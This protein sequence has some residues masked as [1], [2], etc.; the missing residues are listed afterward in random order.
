LNV[1]I[2]NRAAGFGDNAP[3]TDGVRDVWVRGSSFLYI[4]NAYV[5]IFMS[6]NFSSLLPVD[7]AN[8]LLVN[9]VKSARV[10]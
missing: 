5:C 1:K 7:T 8:T 4:Y 2:D 3:E 9:H 6:I 10:S